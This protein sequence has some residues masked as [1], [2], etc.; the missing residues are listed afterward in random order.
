MSKSTFIRISGWALILGA[1]AAS[2][3]FLNWY[4]D[5]NYPLLHWDDNY[6]FASHIAGMMVAP[7]LVAIGLFGLRSRYGE[8][9]GNTGRTILLISTLLGLGLTILGIVSGTIEFFSRFSDFSWDLLL[10]GM[11]F[12]TFGL[13]LFGFQA[14]K[15]KPLPRWNGLPILAGIALPIAYIGYIVSYVL[16]LMNPIDGFPALVG[17]AIMIQLVSMVV[18][19]VILQGDVPEQEASIAAA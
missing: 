10:L 19:G 13:A 1:I 14:L 12:V 11:T 2:M 17:I 18:L 3:I 16:N 7:F 15:S 5:E 6:G 8:A 4:L 9:I